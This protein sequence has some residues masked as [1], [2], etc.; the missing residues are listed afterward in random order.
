MLV[1]SRSR[2]ET[3][4]FP[5]LSVRVEIAQLSKSRVTL[6]ID[7]PKHL[8]IVRG[9]LIDE[10]E[11]QK[12]VP[13]RNSQAESVGFASRIIEIEIQSIRRRLTEAERSLRAGQLS[14]AIAVIDSIRHEDSKEASNERYSNL[15]ESGMTISEPRFA[16]SFAG[17][18]C[19]VEQLS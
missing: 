17:Q 4:V 2:C 13:A 1:L 14:R 18:G 15:C 6:A 12:E 19:L 3:I 11:T 8:Q 16:Y 10:K 7:A 9:E 5:E